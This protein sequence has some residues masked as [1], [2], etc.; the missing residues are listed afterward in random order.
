MTSS[1]T[2]WARLQ[3]P[4]LAAMLP[5][6]RGAARELA[7]QYGLDAQ[8]LPRVELAV[9][10][11][12]STLLRVAF[13]E[14][15][16]GELVIEIDSTP[17]L[18]RLSV[19]SLGLP[20]DHSLIPDFD[21]RASEDELAAGL[22]N[23]GLSAFLLKQMTNRYRLVNDGRQGCRF[24]LEWFIPGPHIAELDS[25]PEVSRIAAATAPEPVECVRPLREEEA[26]GLARLV[27]RGYGYSYVYEDIYYPDR[28]IAHH[29]EGLLKSWVAVT[30]AR[31]L[32]GHVAL[33]K[34]Q[35]DDPAVEWAIA[36][37]DPDWR[38]LG[39]MK[40]LLAAAIED[41]QTRGETVMYAHAVTAHPFTLK[42]ARYFGFQ[43][44]AL[45][46]GYAP[47][48][49]RFRHISERLAQRESTFLTVRCMKPLT[50]PRLYLPAR[51]LEPLQRLFAALGLD[52]DIES[53]PGLEPTEERT[54]FTS[55]ISAA[56]NVAQLDVTRIGSDVRQAIALE[57]HRLCLEHVDVIDLSVDLADPAAPALI[58]AAESCGFFMAGLSPM[59]PKPASLT[60]QYL[61]NISVDLGA[62]RTDG[63]LSAWI[64]QWVAA[65]QRRVE[66][67][68]SGMPS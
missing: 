63:D 39:L 18:F 61:N 58:E 27:Y 1:G 10:E 59:L 38:G 33:M 46:L 28:L 34:A 44:T 26:I 68:A 48:S 11:V 50:L 7:R 64:S 9:E 24:E 12:L 5:L 14:D 51:H 17:S 3:I 60:L 6:V 57:R 31:R 41:V 47:A 21:P 20:F 13:D 32:V 2:L 66:D 8:T 35:R 54:T 22:E 55:R 53:G 37:V 45:L 42:T 67:L 15:E 29:H 23:G 56:V 36:V 19:R 4:A 49:L 62:I 40:Q 52:P 43:P 16:R 65:E 25:A 30:A